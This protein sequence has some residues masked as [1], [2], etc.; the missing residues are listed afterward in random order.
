LTDGRSVMTD[1]TAIQRTRGDLSDAIQ[2]AQ[3][4]GQ[5]NKARM[6][7]QVLRELDTAMESAS[8]GFRQANRSFA[9]ASRDIDAI[10]AGTT[11][12]RR[13][14]TEDII[15]EFQAQTPQGQ[16]AYRTGY[17]DPLIADAQGAAFG[18]NKARPLINDAFADE[19]RAMA[20]GADLMQRRIGRENTMFETRAHALG[21]SRTADNL[22]DEAAM[23][24]DPTIISQVLTGNI[25]G[26]ARSLLSAGSN[27]M[28][29]NTPQVREA[30]AN[31]LLQRGQNVSPQALQRTIDEAVSRIERAQITARLMGRT[32]AGALAAAPSAM[33]QR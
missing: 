12:A 22:A 27:L 20:P 19:S 15:P 14:R 4:A 28:T 3:R 7:G 13:G 30:V 16:A 17:A 29:G 21:G 8:P 11:A 1:F 5:G 6:L 23:G 10:D 26:A 2:A 32:G 9:Q 24:I 31:F 18:A 33:G 25:T